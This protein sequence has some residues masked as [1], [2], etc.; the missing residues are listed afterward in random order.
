MR[1]SRIRKD[2]PPRGTGQIQRSD[3]VKSDESYKLRDGICIMEDLSEEVSFRLEQGKVNRI[4]AG[5][6][7]RGSTGQRERVRAEAMS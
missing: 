7:G 5:R 2:Q 6:D 3:K 1:S 4:Q